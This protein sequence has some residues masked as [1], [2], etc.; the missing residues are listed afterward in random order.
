[1]TEQKNA[2]KQISDVPPTIDIDISDIDYS[3]DVRHDFGRHKSQRELDVK[4][5]DTI[6]DVRPIARLMHISFNVKK[7]NSDMESLII[8]IT[9][10][11]AL[12]QID[13]LQ[14]IST[15]N[16]EYVL[17]F[18]ENFSFFKLKKIKLMFSYLEHKEFF[19]SF[20]E[21]FKEKYP[22]ISVDLYAYP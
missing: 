20:I 1:M 10:W 17:K 9:K 5:T 21:Q 16:N 2:N 6:A 19:E 22:D 18:I 8:E 3:V 14:I 12:C 15:A 7:H 11:L 13:L 4:F